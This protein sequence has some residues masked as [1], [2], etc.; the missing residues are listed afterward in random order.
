[1]RKDEEEA[2]DSAAEQARREALLRYDRAKQL[3]RDA[4][5]D[6]N[7]MKCEL[8]NAT[9]ALGKLMFPAKV[10]VD[11]HFSIWVG[12]RL[13]TVTKITDSDFAVT[14]TGNR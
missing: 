1:M 2:A 10:T 7:R 5:N 14:E 12:R 6:L 9:N 11:D 3:L 8:S 13:I 4:E